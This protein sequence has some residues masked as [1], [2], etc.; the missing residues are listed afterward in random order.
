VSSRWLALSRAK[1]E[2]NRLSEEVRDRD[3]MDPILVIAIGTAIF[4]IKMAEP[5]PKCF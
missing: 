2:A 1:Q 3:E 4:S 5:M